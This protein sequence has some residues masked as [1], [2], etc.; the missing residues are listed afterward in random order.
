MAMRQVGGVESVITPL[1]EQCA[2]IFVPT[3]A[4]CRVVSCTVLDL[5]TRQ[6]QLLLSQIKAINIIEQGRKKGTE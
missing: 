5:R 1:A 3:F 4:S 2:R 6:Q